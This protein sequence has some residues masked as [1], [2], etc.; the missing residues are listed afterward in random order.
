LDGEKI[1]LAAQFNG[2]DCSLIKTQMHKENYSKYKQKGSQF[3]ILS[4]DGW[5]LPF[6]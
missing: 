6:Y 5:H 4:F 3:L 2:C 1:F